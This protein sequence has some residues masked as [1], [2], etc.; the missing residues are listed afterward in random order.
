MLGMVNLVSA[1]RRPFGELLNPEPRTKCGPE[2][3]GLK[4]KG[5]QT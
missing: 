2:L 4:T 5:R 1:R 3:S